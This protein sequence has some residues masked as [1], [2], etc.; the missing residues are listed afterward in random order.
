[1]MI[2]DILGTDG[3]VVKAVDLSPT[4]VMRVGSIPTLCNFYIT[5]NKYSKC[6]QLTI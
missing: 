4:A 1:M 2:I 6:L 5:D 3:R